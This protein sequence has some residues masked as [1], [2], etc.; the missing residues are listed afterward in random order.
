MFNKLLLGLV[1]SIL[2]FSIFASPMTATLDFFNGDLQAHIT[3]PNDLM[4]GKKDNIFLVQFTDATGA[5]LPSMTKQFVSATV[6]MT[7]MDMGIMNVKKVEDVLDTNKQLQG[8]VSLNP[9]F[10]MRGPW[11]MNIKVIINDGNGNPATDVQA[12]TFNVNK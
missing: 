8:V 4:S 7:N 3:G 1:L 12:I 6:E 11:K 5:A 10:S 9:T 2:S